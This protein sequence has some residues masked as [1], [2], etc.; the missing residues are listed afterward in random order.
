MAQP[1]LLTAPPATHTTETR[2]VEGDDGR[3]YRLFIAKPREAAPDAGYPVMYMLDGNAAFGRIE[4]ALLAQFPGLALVGIGYD[5]DTA[6]DGDTRSLDYTPPPAGQTGPLTSP[7]R[8]GRQIGGA[9]QFL[10][11]VTGYIREAAEDG[12]NVDP[13]RRT[14]WGHSYGGLFTLFALFNRP[15]AFHNYVPVSSSIGFADSAITAF[16]AT[17][18][19]AGET[20]RVL[21][22]MG[23]MESRSGQPTL[24][25]PRPSPAALETVE[26]LKQRDDLEI[27]SRVL[28]GAQHGPALGMSLP[29][30]MEFALG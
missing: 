28:E 11:R 12:L 24:A 4:P 9:A 29:F 10:D 25:E 6:F 8:P 14:L 5:V 21:V 15:D 19:R 30:A 16:E 20:K 26:R 3:V 13:A 2:V 27:S 1:A 18:P 17:A 23:D 7:D 22:M